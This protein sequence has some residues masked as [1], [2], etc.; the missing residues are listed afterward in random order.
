MPFL[1]SQISESLQLLAQAVRFLDVR[2]MP[3]APPPGAAA[4]P[5][6]VPAG[7]GSEAASGGSGEPP[8]LSAELVRT[9]WPMLEAVP[10]R[11]GGSPEIA[12]QLFM[13]LGKMLTSLRMVLARQV[14]MIL[15]REVVVVADDSSAII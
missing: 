14:S 4:R 11:L 5:G 6:A 10:K 2:D 1:T 8:H 13:L 7:S 15:G 9:L 12:K 3:S